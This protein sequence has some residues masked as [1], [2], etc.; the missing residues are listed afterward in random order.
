MSI[1]L[2][3]SF[4]VWIRPVTTQIK[5]FK[6][7]QMVSLVYLTPDGPTSPLMIELMLA[8]YHSHEAHGVSEAIWLCTQKRIGVIVIASTFDDPGLDELQR[9]YVTLKLKPETTLQALV[10]ELALRIPGDSAAAC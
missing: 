5:Q 7:L 4:R 10:W 2:L 8:G 9:R 1:S 3:N 6:V